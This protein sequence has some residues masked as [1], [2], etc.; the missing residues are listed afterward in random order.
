MPQ[1]DCKAAAGALPSV[2]LA[3]QGAVNYD[4]GDSIAVTY[5]AVTVEGAT[6]LEMRAC[7]S[8]IDTAGRPWRAVGTTYTENMNKQ[9]R[10]VVAFPDGATPES[11]LAG[12]TITWTTPSDLPNAAMFFRAFVK[13]GE[14]YCD[15]G[16]T[17]SDNPYLWQADK[18]NVTPP[19]MVAAVIICSCI[20]PVL[21]L[22][23]VAWNCFKS[24]SA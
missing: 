10:Y 5:T 4:N 23:Y 24:K 19:A 16:N 1:L 13:C 18:M 6:D 14:D 3:E 20:G 17:P 2:C 15:S 12:G 22:A 7:F 9:C 8:E 11:K 21:L